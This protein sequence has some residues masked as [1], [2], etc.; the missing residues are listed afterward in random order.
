[1]IFHPRPGQRVR[2]HYAKGAAATM[3]YHGRV[4]V[5]RTVAN[6]PGPRN[7]GVEI[8]GHLVTVPRG[9]LRAIAKGVAQ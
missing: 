3:P 7:V 8:D 1:M 5:V 2:V 9:N 4:A 6:G